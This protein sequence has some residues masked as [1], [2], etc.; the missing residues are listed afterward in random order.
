ME[1]PLEHAFP[2]Y[3]EFVNDHDVVV[4]QKVV[5]NGN[6]ISIGMQKAEYRL[7]GGQG[8][9]QE[10]QRRAL[11]EA[12][13][14][15]ANDMEDA[16]CVLE[17][18]NS[19]LYTGDRLGGTKIQ[20]YE[21]K[22]FMECINSSELQEMRSRGPYFTWT[23]KTVWARIDRAFI[24]TYWYDHFDFSQV[25]YMANS[26]SNRTPM[27]LKQAEEEKKAHYIKVMSSLIDINRQQ[28]KAEWI[29]YGDDRT[30]YFFTKT[31]QRKTA[32]YIYEL[33]YEQGHTKQGF[34]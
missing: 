25:T 16:W 21:V 7:L 33:Q 32:T 13:T 5:E 30:K 12:L 10:G 8:A 24:S 31:K 26:L 27:E 3:I 15:I 18:F 28:S 1:I 9:N 17:D 2:E 23:N 4:R 11:W 34:E 6:I 29:S 22:P 14:N 20:D 19:V